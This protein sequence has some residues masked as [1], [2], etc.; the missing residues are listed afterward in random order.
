[1]STYSDLNFRLLA[2]LLVIETG[3][4]FTE[5]ARNHGMSLAPW[6]ELPVFLPD[7]P[8]AEAWSIAAPEAPL[9]PRAQNLPHDAN[10]RAGMKGHAGYGANPGQFRAAVERWISDGWPSSMTVEQCRT[11]DGIVWG[12][13]LHRAH[14]GSGRYG[15]LLAGMPMGRPG[16]RIIVAPGDE[17]PPPAPPMGEIMESGQWWMHTGFT[18]CA[19]FVRPADAC[20]IA[21]LSHRRGPSGELLDAEQLR[22]RRLA[23]LEAG[24]EG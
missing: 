7:G 16:L 11:E 14:A 22:A 17:L 6:D 15:N 9:P 20:C 19:L 13:G 18:G 4:P 23:L 10:A 5:L 21:I 12:L 24:L 8:D 1:V 2:E 3:K